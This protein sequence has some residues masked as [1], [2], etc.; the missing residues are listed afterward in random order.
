MGGRGAGC[1]R[2][3]MPRGI[4]QKATQRGIVG[5]NTIAPAALRQTHVKFCQIL[6]NSV[7][8]SSGPLSN[9]RARQ[10]AAP[11][12]APCTLSILARAAGA[13]IFRPASARHLLQKSSFCVWV[14]ARLTRCSLDA[15]TP[16]TATRRPPSGAP[17][18]SRAAPPPVKTVKFRRSVGP[19][20]KTVKF[21]RPARPSVKSVKVRQN[22][23]PPRAPT[24]PPWWATS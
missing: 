10:K 15:H 16:R 8:V 4:W 3:G 7:C 1:R 11:L 12:P 20:V 14:P 13:E 19:P 9:H 17:G 6:S 21:R 18:P 5:Q 2:G 24:I 22:A 23:D